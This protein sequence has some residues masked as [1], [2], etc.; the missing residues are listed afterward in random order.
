MLFVDDHITFSNSK[1]TKEISNL[2]YVSRERKSTHLEASEPVFFCD[3]V[4]KSY[5]V[6]P[7]LLRAE[8]ILVR[9]L[10]LESLLVIKDG[11]FE[12]L[13]VVIMSDFLRR[14]IASS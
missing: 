4:V 6:E 5:F 10:I 8:I 12:V 7:L 3:E 9:Y 2:T 11:L 1:V 14:T 13:N